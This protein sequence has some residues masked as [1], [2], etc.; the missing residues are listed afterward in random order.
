[1]ETG[2]L[3][4]GGPATTAPVTVT[5][6]VEGGVGA[7]VQDSFD[8]EDPTPGWGI[9]DVGGT[10]SHHFRDGTD[11]SDLATISGNKGKIAIT[12]GRAAIDVISLIG[13]TAA[14][15][16]DITVTAQVDNNADDTRLMVVARAADANHFYVAELNFK[17]NTF[18][19]RKNE[20]GSWTTLAE[21][22]VSLDA[23][24]AYNIRFQLQGS[25]LKAKFW[26]VGTTEP[27]TF[28][29]EVSDTT[30]TS[31]QVGV[32]ARLASARSTANFL[33]DDFLVQ[34]VPG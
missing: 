25:S 8:R 7:Q 2:A 33:F 30:F 23:N 3:L 32:R 17:L 15:D 12:T 4:A 19:I 6:V 14:S 28:S 10:W 16:Y 1:M 21:S 22:S 27:P 9:A 5:A 26:E 29:L 11:A 24:T 13:D 34:D 31:G 18:K 20:G